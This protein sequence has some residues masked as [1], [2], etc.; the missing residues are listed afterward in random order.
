VTEGEWDESRFLY[1][2]ISL[3][4]LCFVSHRKR[5]LLVFCVRQI[6]FVCSGFA[7][8][9]WCKN[10]VGRFLKNISSVRISVDENSKEN[11]GEISNYVFSAR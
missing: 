6:V 11:G 3:A 10:F 7:K 8:Y 1:C 5:L 2:A 9:V 4:E